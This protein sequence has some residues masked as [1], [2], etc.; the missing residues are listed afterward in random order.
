VKKSFRRRKEELEKHLK[1]LYDKRASPTTG[2]RDFSRTEPFAD[3]IE[4][5]K[6]EIA[7]IDNR[8][9]RRRDIVISL[10]IGSIIGSTIA[11]L[12]TKLID[13]LF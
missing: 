1:A 3:E 7:Q 9:S 13:R 4:Q 12:I 6:Y 10:I 8:I 11:A 2:Y 5:T